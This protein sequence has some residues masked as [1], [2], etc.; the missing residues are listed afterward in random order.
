MALIP[1]VCLGSLDNDIQHWDPSPF[2]A[3]LGLI[4]LFCATAGTGIITF[5]YFAI[6]FIDIGT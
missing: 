2:Y 6:T 5:Q 4:I 1:I 3:L